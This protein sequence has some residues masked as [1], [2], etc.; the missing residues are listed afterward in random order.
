MHLPARAQARDQGMPWGSGPLE[1]HGGRL[2][3]LDFAPLPAHSPRPSTWCVSFAKPAL[4]S[5]R[6]S[7][8]CC[9]KAHMARLCTFVRVSTVSVRLFYFSTVT[10]A[11]ACACQCPPNPCACPL[12]YTRTDGRV[13]ER[14]G[15]RESARARVRAVTPKTRQMA[16][17]REREREREREGRRMAI[18]I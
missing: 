16:I 15:G 13:T 2:H 6:F 14:E 9:A 4:C 10:Y 8:C 5:K 17:E 1:V 12:D 18:C 7:C 11:R 3:L